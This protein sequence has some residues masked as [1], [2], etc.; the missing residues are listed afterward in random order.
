MPALH[1]L[2]LA[3]RARRRCRCW[4]PTCCARLRMIK[5]AGR[6]R[7]AA[8]G[9]A[10]RSTGCTPGCRSSWCRAAPRPTSPPT[11]PKRLWPK[12]IRR[13]RSSSSAPA[14]TAPTRTT[15][16]P[17]ASCRPATS[18]SSTSAARTSPATTPTP[19]APTASASRSP[20]WR[21]SI[22]CCSARSRRPSPRCG[23]GSPPSRSTPP[24]ATCWPRPGWPSTSC[25]APGTAS[26]CR[27]T[28]S[29]TS[30]PATTCR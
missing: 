4:P 26:G 20:K 9:R 8:Q 13:W 5:D 2:P 27:C 7:R 11:S 30:S 24:P 12:G 15:S 18:S 1:L 25:T 10:R 22:R 3:E 28:R 19:P 6:D 29:P 14:R 23:P 21:N 17:T 16:A